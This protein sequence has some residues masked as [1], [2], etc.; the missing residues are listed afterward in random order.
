AGIT[1]SVPVEHI[2][3]WEVEWRHQRQHRRDGAAAAL[4]R[5][6]WEIA[7]Q[8][9]T[10][11]VQTIRAYVGLLYRREKLQLLNETLQTNE[12]LVKNVH[13]L[14][15]DLGKLKTLYLI[16]A[17][18]EV[19]DTRD[20]LAAGGEALTA[21]RQDLFG[22]LGVVEAVFE[23]EGPFDT[24]P[25]KWDAAALTELALARRA[26]LHARQMAVAEASANVRLTVA[27]R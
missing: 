4:S 26:D 14:L 17:Q 5:T 2:L 6:D 16:Q 8:E 27:N 23:V 7:F 24:P 13:R 21:A 25:W 22:S 12:Q 10:L 18:S 11:A 9:Q 20:L 1:N 19:T 3:I 15:I